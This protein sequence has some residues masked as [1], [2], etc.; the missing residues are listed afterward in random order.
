LQYFVAPQTK[1]IRGRIPNIP[2]CKQNTY[3]FLTEIFTKIKA[4]QRGTPYF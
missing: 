1:K 4:H 2:K 3:P